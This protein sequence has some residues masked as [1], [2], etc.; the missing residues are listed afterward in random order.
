LKLNLSGSAQQITDGPK[1][2]S[3]FRPCNSFVIVL[4]MPKRE[5]QDFISHWSAASASERANSQPFLL[6]LCDLLDVPRPDPQPDNGYFFEFPVV[7][8]HPDGT[9]SNGRIDLYRRAHFVLESKQ[10]QEAKAKASQLELAAEEAGVIARKKSSQPVR[11]TGAWDDAMMKA[12]GQAERYV[13]AIPD[14][15]PPF[16]IVVDVG[17]SFE[18]YADFSQAGKAYLPF[19]DPRTFRIRLADL[20]DDKIRER[21]TGCCMNG[22]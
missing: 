22:A 13:R 12:R 4:T 3:A 16:I 10:F 2:L 11:G 6:E 17:H 8:Q 14:D 18:I 7:E 1:P 5:V 19:P 9:T 21:L 20:A 15:N